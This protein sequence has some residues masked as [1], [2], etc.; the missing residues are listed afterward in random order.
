[1]R[2]GEDVVADV[3]DIRSAARRLAAAR[4]RAEAVVG[5]LTALGSTT[6]GLEELAREVSPRPHAR[7]LDMLMSMGE[8][9][10]CALVAM[11]LVDLGFAAVSL[12]GSQAGIVTDGAHGNARIVAVRADRVRDAL[13]RGAI[14]LVAGFQGVSND[15]EVTRLGQGGGEATAV[16]LAAELGADACEL[17]TALPGV[18]TADPRVVHSTRTIPAVTHDELLELQSH[19]ARVTPL[20]CLEFARNN[21]VTLHVR[22]SST[23]AE[24]TWVVMEEDGRMLERAIISGVSHTID[25]T[26]YRVEGASASLLFTALAEAGV[27]VD[28]ILQAGDGLLFSSPSVDGG[29]TSGVLDALGVSWSADADLGE[30][31]IVGAGM[32]SHPGIAATAFSTLEQHGIEPVI[33]TT[34]PIRISCHV[35]REAVERAV[36]ALHHAFGLDQAEGATA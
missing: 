14:V 5:I 6:R 32:K 8:R 35:R 12:T 28:T 11:A 10:S 13:E 23:D 33:V 2:F 24:G 34:S 25:A 15:A 4:D 19:G 7:E 17:L 9:A 29:P 31:S 20:P 22:S 30:V 21:G 1:M 36:R 16:A 26:V 27:N 18:P 3:E